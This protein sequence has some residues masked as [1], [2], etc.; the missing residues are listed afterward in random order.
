MPLS[1]PSRKIKE[2]EIEQAKSEV[3]FREKH[4]STSRELVERMEKLS[5]TGGISQVELLQL[6]LDLAESEKDQSVAQRTLQQVILDRQKMETDHARQRG[7]AVSE[8]GK[9]R[10]KLAALQG[11]LE[12]SQ[13]SL[14]TVQAPYDAVV[15][16]VSQR[17]VGNVV[18]NGQELCQLARVEATP[19]ARLLLS[20]AGLSKLT[21]GLSTKLFFDAFPYQRYGAVNARLDWIS[22]SAVNSQ[23]GPRFVGVATIQDWEKR[24]P[25]LALRVGMRGEA[26]IVTGKRTLIESFFEPI[27]ELKENLAVN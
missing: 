17:S 3:E 19:Q 26:R 12:N 4:A 20:E 1:P 22:P 15:I 24:P 25:K 21:A 9:L 7:D 11:D 23:E 14:L 27:K 16:S 18:Q 8:I 5:K 6:G 13:L 10:V 2:A